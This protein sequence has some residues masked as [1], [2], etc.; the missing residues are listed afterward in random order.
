MT[1]DLDG[2]SKQIAEAADV[3]TASAWRTSWP[4]IV[5][6][7]SLGAWL[8]ASSAVT[9]ALVRAERQGA[10]LHTTG[11]L[12]I[13]AMVLLQMTGATGIIAL[14]LR[15]HARWRA[16][17]TEVVTASSRE[18][19]PWLRVAVGVAVLP[20]WF[21]LF[22][23]LFKEASVP[24]QPLAWAALMSVIVGLDLVIDAIRRATPAWRRRTT[25]LLAI[26]VYIVYAIAVAVGAPQPWARVPGGLGMLLR[27]GVPLLVLAVLVTGLGEVHS[28]LQFRRLQHL[29]NDIPPTDS[30]G[31]D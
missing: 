15:W 22:G 30:H 13:G 19:Y 4:V 25:G 23:R 29:V 18:R 12:V 1:T 14:F 20:L 28:R 3:Y 26:G 17:H 31:S 10:L 21:F 2:R 27:I 11:V 6:A 8:G 7:M 9:F 16:L 24:L 5:F